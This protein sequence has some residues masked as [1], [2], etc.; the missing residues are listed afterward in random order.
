MASQ[1]GVG[2][3]QRQRV[4]AEPARDEEPAD[5]GD[6]GAQ[7]LFRGSLLDGAC[8]LDKPMR[9]APRRA[10]DQRRASRGAV[11]TGRSYDRGDITVHMQRVAPDS[12]P[13][14]NLPLSCKSRG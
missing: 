4:E 14:G 3:A 8:I 13:R 9:I 12:M 1:I 11:E 10:Q 5:R 7:P 2:A 6:P